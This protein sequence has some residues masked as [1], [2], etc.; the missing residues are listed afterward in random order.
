V[1]DKEWKE[2]GMGSV[3]KPVRLVGERPN[4]M[5]LGSEILEDQ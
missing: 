5:V 3:L 4:L 2:T 1:K